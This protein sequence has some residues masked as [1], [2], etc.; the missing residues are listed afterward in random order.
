VPRHNWGMHYAASIRAMDLTGPFRGS[1][2]VAE[3]AVTIRQLRSGLFVRLFR[4]VYL[5]ARIPV[6][7]EIRCRGAGLVVPSTAVLTGHSAA[8]LYGVELAS[9]ADPVELLVAEDDPFIAHPGM[10]VRHVPV[11]RGEYESHDGIRVATPLRM[12]MDLL[13]NTKLR[14]ALSH[15]VGAVDAILHRGIVDLGELTVL[16]A[17]RHDHGIVRARKAAA[18]A[19]RRAES[20]PESVLRVLLVRAGIEVTPQFEVWWRGGFLA[21]VDLAVIERRVAIEYDG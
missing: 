5:P 10:G 11:M 18:L 1:L 19:D 13:V 8:V 12:A 2:A 20:V 16:L 3:D 6:T 14:K 17:R 9:A 4:D 7:H 15:A 21:R